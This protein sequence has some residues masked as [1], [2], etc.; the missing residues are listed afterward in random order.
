MDDK[1]KAIF[2]SAKNL[3]SKKGFKDTNISDIAKDAGIAVGTYYNYY[4]SK[5]ELFLK[6]LVIRFL[7]SSQRYTGLENF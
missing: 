3:F 5:E 1:K 4:S 7:L 2:N 6:I